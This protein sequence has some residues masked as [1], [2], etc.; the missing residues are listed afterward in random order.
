MS[1]NTLRRLL[2][3]NWTALDA[4]PVS[5]ERRLRVS[6]LPIVA[7]QGPLAV[8]VDHDGHRHLL[9]P[10]HAHR[11]VRQG[12]NGPVLHMR[13]RPLEDADTYQNYVDLGCLRDDL[14]DLFTNLCIDVLDAVEGLPENP[15][16]ALYRVLDR[17]KAL[18]Q[19]QSAPLGSEQL[20]GLFGELSLLSRLLLSDPS[21]HR[22]WR[23]PRGDRHDFSAGT[24]AIEV[25][26][27]VAGEGRRPRIHGLDQLEAPAGG[28]LGLVWF[29][30]QRTGANG[31]GAAFTDAV[32]LARRLCDDE[33]ALLGLLASAGYHP[34]DADRYQDVHFVIVEER[35]YR[36]DETFPGL[37]NRTLKAAGVPVSVLDVE[38]TVDLSGEI[39]APLSQDDVSQMIDALIREPM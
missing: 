3:D 8:A 12:L 14:D 32:D 18:F 7:D 2:D 33:F 5:G 39:P 28:T 24:T 16:K 36:V 34:S 4:E 20:A 25:K 22:L 31:P 13:K 35:W 38:Y 21:A 10:I 15:V 19:T 37:T 27:S 29:R 9:V 17:W 23:G 6:R 11:K 30:L 1:E 26:A